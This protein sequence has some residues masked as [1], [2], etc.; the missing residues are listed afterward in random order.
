MCYAVV[1]TK[2]REPKLW[3]VSFQPNHTM[4]LFGEVSSFLKVTVKLCLPGT[5]RFRQNTA[6]CF[7][8]ING[9]TKWGCY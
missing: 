9:G 7:E 5:R 4:L 8:R 1:Q 2:P 6:L 3:S